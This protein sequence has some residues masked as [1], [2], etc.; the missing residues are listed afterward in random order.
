MG[1]KQSGTTVFCDLNLRPGF[2]GTGVIKAALRASDILK[3]SREEWL[4]I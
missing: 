4:E 3:L 2:Y 1:Q